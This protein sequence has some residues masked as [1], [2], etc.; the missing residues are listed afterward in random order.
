MKHWLNRLAFESNGRALTPNEVDM[1]AEYAETLPDRLA[2]AKKLEESLKW[3]VRHLSDFI[4]PRAAEWGLPKDPFS[5]DFAQ[6]LSAIAHAM[7][8]NDVELLNST[9]V[10]PYIQTA[11][12]LEVPVEAFADLFDTAWQALSKRLDPRSTEL[13]A[14]HFSHVIGELRLAAGWSPSAVSATSYTPFATS[15]NAH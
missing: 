10:T 13:L 12:A 3:L 11:E 4:A 9:I 6:C 1:I 8:G 14:P 5:N 7:I 15:L 2:A